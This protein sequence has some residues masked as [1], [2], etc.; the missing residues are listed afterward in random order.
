MDMEPFR[1]KTIRK[2]ENSKNGSEI[3]ARE[4]KTT[5]NQKARKQSFVQIPISHS[6]LKN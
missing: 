6:T 1:K 4:Q 5:K 3:A 2:I